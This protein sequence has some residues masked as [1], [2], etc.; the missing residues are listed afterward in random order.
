MSMHFDADEAVFLHRNAHHL[1]NPTTIAHRMHK[2]KSIKAIRVGSDDARHITVGDRIVGMEGGEDHRLADP[3]PGGPVKISVERRSTV[4]RSGEAITLTRMAMAVDDGV[5]GVHKSIAYMKEELI[6]VD[7]GCSI[8]NRS[9]WYCDDASIVRVGLHL[10]RGIANIGTLGGD[11]L[12]YSDRHQ[13]NYFA[14]H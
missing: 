13:N 14:R 6:A 11:W 8:R 3:G 9:R 5:I 10:W 12:R 4:P 2:D 1:P 7:I